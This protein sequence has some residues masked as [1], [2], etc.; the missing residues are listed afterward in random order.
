MKVRIQVIIQHDDE[1]S[2]TIVEEIG[3][4]QRGDARPETL[5]LT[6]DEGKALLGSIQQEMVKQQI[7]EY[8]EHQSTCQDCGQPYRRNGRH[9]IT[10]RTLFGKMQLQSP[11]FYPCT[12][13]SRERKSF[14][15]V[16][17][18]LPERSAPE[19]CYL[20]TKWASL[21]SYGLTVDLLE[22]VLPLKTN[23]TS[24]YKH[25]HQTAERIESELGAEQVMFAH[26]CEYDR[27]ALPHPDEPLTVGIDGGFVHAR[28]GDNRKAGWFE[29][30]VGKSLQENHD[31]KRFGFVTD[32]DEKPKRRLYETLRAQGLQMNQAITFLSDGGD[33]VRNLQYYMSP[34]AEHI[35]DWFHITMRLTVMGNIAKGL[36]RDGELKHAPGELER[37]KWFLWHGNAYKAL[38]AL[39]FLEMDLEMVEIEDE[40]AAKLY[41]YVQE[42]AIYIHN[43][44]AFIPNYGDRYRYGEMI[45]TAFVESTVNELISKRMVKKQQMRWTKGGA[46]LLLQTRIKTLDG[47][48]RDKFVEWYPGMGVSS[49][50]THLS[51]AASSSL[52]C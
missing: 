9:H 18:L 36:P 20:Q 3:C 32:H 46:H 15:P 42:F 14:S 16:A 43:N 2:E 4:L 19:L 45:S 41:K 34:V 6:L 47:D 23:F 8:I 17:Y 39:R 26:G 5:G 37:I 50:A 13:R 38:E 28:D 48:L 33:T 21:M 1:T 35:L 49:T 30:I 27:H 44:R 52:S 7:A 40:V 10:Y 31:P 12:C 29:V 11:R 51:T 22:E 24:V 25:T